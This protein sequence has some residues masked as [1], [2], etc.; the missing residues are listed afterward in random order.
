[1]D[2]VKPVSLFIFIVLAALVPVVA[3]AQ[4]STTTF[5]TNGDGVIDFHLIQSDLFDFE[6]FQ[7][8]QDG[9]ID[10]VHFDTNKNGVI[11]PG[12]VVITC[13]RGVDVHIG[14]DGSGTGLRIAVIHCEEPGTGRTQVS[15]YQVLDKN[16]DGDTADEGEVIAID[17]PQPGPFLPPGP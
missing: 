15:W 1:M 16:G 8:G 11:D 5:D 2:K 9:V 12:E 3:F 10:Q 7:P 6:N 4:S 17:P 13:L 14:G